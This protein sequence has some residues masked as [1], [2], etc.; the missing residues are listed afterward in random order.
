MKLAQLEL[1]ARPSLCMARDLFIFSYCTRGMA[2]VD[3]AF[4]KKKNIHRGVLTYRR[5]K[6]KQEMSVHIEPCI[7]NIIDKY[8]K[9][10]ENS[11]YV[12]PILTSTNEVS[13]LR[14]YYTAINY[15]N[16]KLKILAEMAGVDAH[17]TSYTSR[18]SWAT[19]ARNHN[20]PLSVI[21]AGMGHTSEKTTEIYL[22]SM[23]NSVIDD[24]NKNVLQELSRYISC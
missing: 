14:Q 10:T 20:I 18:H 23:Q 13:A 6:T 24:A 9:L 15:H 3:I 4:L 21:S 17:L 8:K 5:R 1:D 11:E 16:R 12:F 2:F 7:Q 22:A 19:T